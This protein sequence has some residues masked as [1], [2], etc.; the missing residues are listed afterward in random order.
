M[1]MAILSAMYVSSH[2]L[3]EEYKDMA[4]QSSQPKS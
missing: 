2:L 4:I 3:E 1:I